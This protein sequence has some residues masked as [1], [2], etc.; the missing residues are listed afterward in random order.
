MRGLTTY[1]VFGW[2]PYLSLAVFLLG[3]WLRFAGEQHILWSG[4]GP[5]LRRQQLTW[6]VTLFHGGILILFL[7]H[8]IGLLTPIR[9]FD[10]VGISHSFKQ[11]MAIVIGGAAGAASLI[12]LNLLLHRR[13]FD[14]R[15]RATSSFADIGFQLLICAKLILGLGTIPVALIEYIDGCAILNFMTWAQGILTLRPAVASAQVA[16]APLLFKLHMINGMTLFLVFPFTR[17][18]N[19]WSVPIWYLGHRGEPLRPRPGEAG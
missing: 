16:D 4:S 12:G 10:A 9:V 1:L 7:G 19:I 17:L 15:I 2:Y 13:L 3:S 18:V 5:L 6:G 11:W 8:F 14:A